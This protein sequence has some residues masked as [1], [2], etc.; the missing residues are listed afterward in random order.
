MGIW[1]ATF[2]ENY[3]TSS[4]LVEIAKSGVSQVLRSRV[5]MLIAVQYLAMGFFFSVNTVWSEYFID[6]YNIVPTVH[7]AELRIIPV[8]VTSLLGLVLLLKKTDYKA[9][10]VYPLICTAAL[11]FVMPVTT[12]WQ[13]SYIVEN[14]ISAALLIVGVGIVLLVND[15]IS[16]NRAT[17]LSVLALLYVIPTAVS[18]F[19]LNRMV[20]GWE[21]KFVVAGC[22]CVISLLL[23]VWAVKIHERDT[24]S[25][26]SQV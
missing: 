10:I 8:V 3:G 15:V 1:V 20:L 21:E 5:L 22:C 12:I 14:G 18:G 19:L 7:A 13:L 26:I 2:T 11:F 9:F 16:E 4:S 17:T 24:S 25:G 6:R 23:L